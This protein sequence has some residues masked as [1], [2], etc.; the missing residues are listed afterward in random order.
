VPKN[1]GTLRVPAEAGIHLPLFAGFF[2]RQARLFFIVL[3]CLVSLVQAGNLIP[4]APDQ[5][6]QVFDSKGTLL[7]QTAYRDGRKV[8]RFTSYW[9]G[10]TPRVRTLYDGDIIEGEYRSWHA[11]GRL[12]E[13][14]HYSRGHEAGMQQ[15]W[16]ERGDLFLNFEVRGGR[17][18]GLVNSRP[19]LPMSGTM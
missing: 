3:S 18:Y 4:G 7:A 6:V 11:N 14:K 16:T 12:A 5:V 9:P 8:G 17:H 15:A 19:C 2:V 13:L 1:A 10:G